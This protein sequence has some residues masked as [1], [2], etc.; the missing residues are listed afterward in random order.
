MGS[1]TVANVLHCSKMFIIGKIVHAR[2]GVFG[3]G[4]VGGVRIQNSM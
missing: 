3:E 4:E 2:V 1:L